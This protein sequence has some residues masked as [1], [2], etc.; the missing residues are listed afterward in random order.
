MPGVAV[1]AVLVHGLWHGA[2]CWDEARERL[3]TG[4]R[5]VAVELPMTSFSADIAAVRE[6]LD[7][8]DGP[9]LLAGHSYGGA[10]V[11]A[12]GAHPSVRGLL[13]LAA[14]AL[15]EGESVGR[16][17]PDADIAPTRLADAL[18]TSADGA[19][20]LLDPDAARELLY[21][22]AGA[23]VA[24]EAI[25]RLRPV[26]R[27]L[28]SARA[29][30][31]AWAFRPTDYV[32]CADDRCVAPALQRAMAERIGAVGTLRSAAEWDSDHCPTASSPQLVAAQLAASADALDRRL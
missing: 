2:W 25:G 23:A 20:V 31:P 28:F 16:V 4:L 29:G 3:G 11:T 18:R 9:V 21:G 19:Q 27:S 7:A 22:H 15:A 24:A 32:T 17:L 12:A 13:Y 6:C 8:L 5:C 10:V 30:A 1:T 14:F 26:A